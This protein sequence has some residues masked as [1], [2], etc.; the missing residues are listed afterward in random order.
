M[1]NQFYVQPAS[2]L[3]GF[4]D[5]M[6]SIQTRSELEQA[7]AQEAA[8][9]EKRQE[10]VQLMQSGSPE[11][12]ATFTLENPWIREDMDAAIG[13]VNDQTKQNAIDSAKQI[14]LEGSD[15]VQ[16][17]I[18][19]A[20][21]VIQQG[22]DASGTMS[23]AQQAFQDPQS[24]ISEAEKVL[25]IYDPES[26][27]QYRELTKPV[28]EEGV[29]GQPAEVQTFE[30]LTDGLSPEDKEIAK[31]VKLGLQPRATEDAVAKG[32]KA[33]ATESGKLQAKL[34]LEP[35][36]A[37]ATVAAKNEANAIATNK[38]TTRSNEKAWNTYNSAM[39]NL[40]K[41]MSGTETGPF[42]G[43]IPAVT[44][45][46]QIAEGATAVM[47]PILKQ[48]FRS[49]GEG[50]FTDKDQELLM[51][52]VPTR[53]DTPESRAAKIKAIDEVVKAKLGI[54][55]SET[56]RVN[57]IGQASDEELLNMLGGM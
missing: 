43:F 12:I 22:G 36:V 34:G 39:T 4:Q 32:K 40:A 7:K 37:A 24:A 44:S 51:G 30:F 54:T 23:L 20:E 57:N 13:F 31:R 46:Q 16:T 6:S 35:Q 26:L 14:L 56:G 18:D 11:D 33:F 47:A 53:K 2:T 3:T 42:V 1:T 5:L 17:L 29:E 50:T 15:P 52:M 48:M 41:A 45:N 28:V 49:S 25:A 10:A 9:M 38:E 55:D 8:K 19:R 27:N 21:T